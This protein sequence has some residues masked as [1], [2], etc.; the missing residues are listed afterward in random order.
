MS[1]PNKEKQMPIVLVLSGLEGLGLFVSILLTKSVEGGIIFGLSAARMATAGAVLAGSVLL[2]ILGLKWDT[3]T[4]L[5]RRTKKTIQDHTTTI[6][7]FLFWACVFFSFLQ[8]PAWYQIILAPFD[9]LLSPQVYSQL[10][11]LLIWITAVLIQLALGIT[12]TQKSE[13]DH[14]APQ[15][16]IFLVWL[17]LGIDGL[18]SG[19]VQQT[20]DKE[21]WRKFWHTHK[22]S[23]LI[24][25]G[26]LA[27][28]IGIAVTNIGL[29][30]DSKF[31]NIAGIPILWHQV[32]FIVLL[33]LCLFDVSRADFS[34]G[35]DRLSHKSI[36]PILAVILIWAAAVLVW[37]IEPLKH[38]YF[39]PGPYPPNYVKYPFSDARW[40][41]TGGQYFL[42]GEGLNNNR[43]TDRPYLMIY[44]AGLHLLGG[45]QY[46]RIAF[47][48]IIL[49]AFIPAGLFLISWK[50]HS[51]TAGLA[52]AALYILKE[53]N[54]IAAAFKIGLVNPKV[55]TSELPNALL[56][57]LITICLL[58]WFRQEKPGILWPIL[59]G[60]LT[61]LAIGVRGNSLIILPLV[62][63]LAVLV[64]LKERILIKQW[65]LSGAF[66]LLGAGVLLAPY[67]IDN[68]IHHGS[69]FW[70]TKIQDVLIRSEEQPLSFQTTTRNQK[71]VPSS[72]LQAQNI[73]TKEYALMAA[74]HFF[75]NEI[76]TVLMLPIN[77]QA[78]TLN[79][80]IQH[81]IWDSDETWI[82]DLTAGETIA[83]GINLLILAFG[84]GNAAQRWGITGLAPVAIH[85]MYNLTNAAAHTSG[86]RYLV[87]TDWV[88]LL[89]FAAGIIT[90]VQAL[91]G[92]QTP[93]PPTVPA[94]SPASHKVI[95]PAF[96][97]VGFL[98][99]GSI[100]LVSSLIPQPYEL[101]NRDAYWR[102]LENQGDNLAEI[103][104]EIS[105]IETFMM[106]ENAVFNLG[107]ALYPR[108]YQAGEETQISSYL[109]RIPA[110][111]ARIY[112]LMLEA[113]DHRH[114]SIT[115][116]PD[117]PAPAFP[118]GAYG[119]IIGCKQD[120]YTEG[121]LF[122]PLSSADS[123]I[124]TEGNL[125]LT[126]D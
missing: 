83:L 8:S 121:K 101:G 95:L 113:N 109:P 108:Y 59:A 105:Q 58:H 97:L 52:V 36:F 102:Y 4:G 55:L 81:P 67:S 17:L 46:D 71:P 66:F 48:Q 110:E 24:F 13:L 35:L 12:L 47:F 33:A 38:T 6:I 41:D 106:E 61:G 112:F 7:F 18:F 98:L 49:L 126:C 120:G 25:L 64:L 26:M 51:K 77:W 42:M 9:S 86:G 2:F 73:S 1:P 116:M 23:L 28:W 124:L 118:H 44:H 30:P 5:T 76:T 94:E 93:P 45:Q 70:L 29:T 92:W 107:L 88:L 34:P 111:D 65:L 16:R 40:F 119:L 31:W 82:G 54:A 62:V 114:V 84:I 20:L 104:L 72:E 91:R 122:I 90:I 27:V 99:I 22:T 32:V 19:R 79:D 87:S 39:S 123:R 68:L 80:A 21:R 100:F 57:V 15:Q 14:I 11:P 53:K 85:L 56:L 50:L 74:G 103:G 60:G 3:Q 43:L 69:P 125:S 89:Y 10:R 78:V 115:L 75:H 37:Q 117:E 63:L 96:S